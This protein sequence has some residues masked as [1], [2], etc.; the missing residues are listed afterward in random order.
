[1]QKSRALKK[2][3]SNLPNSPIKQAATIAAFLEDSNSPVVKILESK[4]LVPSPEEKENSIL[5]NS[6][7]GDI[8]E[9]VLKLKMKRCDKS[10]EVMDF[11]TASVSG[12]SVKESRSK[13]SLAKKLG[14]PVRRI[15]KA[16]VV[17]NKIF[18]SES[19]SFTYT[20][21]KTRSDALSDENRKLIYEFW[22]APENS[23]P[24]GNKNDVKRVRIGPKQ[25]SSHAVQILEKSQ[26]EIYNDFKLQYPEIKVCQRL[27][28]ACKPYY[29]RSAGP[30]DKVTCCCRYH[31][32][33]KY[34][35]RACMTYRKTYVSNPNLYEHI[36]ELVSQTLCP[37][38]NEQYAKAC[39]DRKCEQ[40]GVHK[41]YL[42]HEERESNDDSP[43][44]TW[45]CFEYKTV[46]SKGGETKKLMMT[47]KITKPAEVFDYLKQLL[48]K[49]PSHNMR[50]KWQMQ[51][52]KNLQQSLPQSHCITIHDFSE[53]YKCWDKNEI[54]SNY[55][56]RTEVSIHVTI[57]HRHA[58]LEVDGIE[59]TMEDPNL[60]TEH[61][62]TISPDEKHDQYFTH[63]CQ[64]LVSEYLKSIS[65]EVHTMHE[66]CDGC[67]AQYKSRHCFGDVSESVAEFGYTT[68][69]RNFFETSHAK[70]PQDAA[71]GFLKN[72]ADL[73]ILRGQCI[74][75]NA[76][77]LFQFANEKLQNPKGVSNVKR[78]IF[79]FVEE[80]PRD[81]PRLYSPLP[82]IRSIHQLISNISG[83]NYVRYLSCYDCE[84]CLEGNVTNCTNTD[85]LGTPTST[86]FSPEMRSHDINDA[87]DETNEYHP[88]SELVS[89]G[90]ILAL[91]SEESDYY[92]FKAS[93]K[94]TV[95]EQD[96][97]DKWGASYKSG[98]EVLRGKYF[99]Q[100]K[101]N[102]LKFKIHQKKSAIVPVKSILYMFSKNELPINGNEII[103]SEDTHL[104]ILQSVIDSRSLQ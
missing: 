78:R 39:L 26:T 72:Q 8:K 79:R 55:F 76:K 13:S 48:H 43:D 102:P 45:D 22:C 65:C 94:S 1:M 38:N 64:K 25:Y 91:L 92:L 103:L 41:L 84:E 30:K 16:Y 14:L 11:L 21:R 53:N 15:S 51:Q 46:K 32:E 49:F 6:V 89:K 5:Q 19:S 87:V 85:F 23:H 52:L 28:E 62:F 44:V 47:K 104:S 73:A 36:N 18:H 37:P 33:M 101:E 27:F 31:L 57:I 20:K 70:G 12:D 2:L 83:N 3:K 75:Q 58:I 97:T 63:H 82:G 29:I 34:V 96:E 24:T 67:A 9:S 81:P 56:Q 17:R 35:F 7:L 77:K 66:F 71:G 74:I 69:T 40:C 61:F 100:S 54:Q 90:C 42:Y 99:I 60:I 50:A 86:I 88:L 95:L 98:D 10:R 68:L 59:S 93:S 4:N 80:I